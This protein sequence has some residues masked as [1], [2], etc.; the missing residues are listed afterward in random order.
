MWNSNT[1]IYSQATETFYSQPQFQ[2]KDRHVSTVMHCTKAAFFDWDAPAK[3]LTA[4]RGATVKVTFISPSVLIK[5]QFTTLTGTFWEDIWGAADLLQQVWVW[6]WVLTRRHEA[7]NLES[8]GK[9][10]CFCWCYWESVQGGK[11]PQHGLC[12]PEQKCSQM[13]W[14]L[15][16]NLGAVRYNFVFTAQHHKANK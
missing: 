9:S 2:W 15:W 14:G 13:S 12:A 4:V 1:H 5:Q 16:A 3:D 8:G 10:S 7:L 6:S 11:S